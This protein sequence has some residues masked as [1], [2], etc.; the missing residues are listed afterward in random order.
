MKAKIYALQHN[1]T[2]DLVALL[3]GKHTIGCKWV[4]NVKYL[5]NGSVDQYKTRFVAKG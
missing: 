5:V 4:F 1:R 3:E 2:W